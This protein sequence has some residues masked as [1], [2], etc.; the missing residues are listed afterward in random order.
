MKPGK[1]KIKFLLESRRDKITKELIE[2]NVPINM[3]VT[4]NGQRLR[5]YTNYRIDVRKWNLETER[6]RNNNTNDAGETSSEINQRIVS[7]T[8][9]VDEIFRYYENLK[10]FP[11]VA[12]L[13]E[14]LRNRLNE[15]INDKQY[16]GHSFFDRFEQYIK[17]AELS[18]LRKKQV[19]SAMNHL[20]NYNAFTTFETINLNG[21]KKHLIGAKDKKKS[22]NTV[23]GILKKVRTF[24]TYARIKKWT[25]A[26]PFENY[27]IGSEKYGDPIYITKAER[28][29]IFEKNIEN[30]R[31]AR[32]M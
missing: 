26:N 7:L 13:R 32:V 10:T 17:E 22:Q 2:N 20:K 11:T 8:S 27:V 14:E 1:Y 19:K 6:V 3:D 18:P 23:V 21:F 29:L 30:G 24:Y 12:Q 9:T 4:F 31:L 25:K 28:D 5:F 15:N 16:T